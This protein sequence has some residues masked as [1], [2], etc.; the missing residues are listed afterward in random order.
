MSFLTSKNFWMD[1]LERAVK[2]SA[3]F[4]V[5]GAGGNQL[6]LTDLSLP[7][8]GSLA[9]GGAMVSVVTSLVSAPMGQPGSASVLPVSSPAKPERS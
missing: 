3:Q 5:S 4:V 1:V 8:I 7:Q 2:T 6:G 9:L